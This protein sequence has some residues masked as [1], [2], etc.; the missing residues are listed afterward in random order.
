[1]QAVLAGGESGE[2]GEA[3]RAA[4]GVGVGEG[5]EGVHAV[6]AGLGCGG[7]GLEGGGPGGWPVRP[8]GGRGTE[9]GAVFD[10]A[11]DGRRGI[12]RNVVRQWNPLVHFRFLIFDC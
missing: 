3:D 6:I 12:R 1:M 8:R 4:F 11:G 10:E 2:D 9:G 7:D 5:I